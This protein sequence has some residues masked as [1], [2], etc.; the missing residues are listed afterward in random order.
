MNVT[1]YNTDRYPKSLIDEND[2]ILVMRFLAVSA[3][4]GTSQ[5]KSGCDLCGFDSC[6]MR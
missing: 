6:F 1:I 2:L 5:L 3:A 4:D